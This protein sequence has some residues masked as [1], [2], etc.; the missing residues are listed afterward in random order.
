MADQTLQIQWFDGLQLT[1]RSYTMAWGRMTRQTLQIHCVDLP[2]HAKRYIYY[3]VGGELV[4]NPPTNTLVW[5]SMGHPTL[6]IQRFATDGSPN[7]T[8]TID[9]TVF[10]VFQD[11]QRFPDCLSFTGFRVLFVFQWFRSF[12]IFPLTAF[13]GSVA[14]ARLTAFP[15]SEVYWVHGSWIE[16]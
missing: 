8:N 9:F 6:H 3:G 4:T 7:R 15:W 11:C 5:I 1:K 2:W 16:S 12:Q 13:P 10:I 14:G